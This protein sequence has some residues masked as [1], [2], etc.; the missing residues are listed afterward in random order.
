VWKYVYVHSTG[1]TTNYIPL[2]HWVAHGRNIKKN[3]VVFLFDKNNVM[4]NYTVHASQSEV[5]REGSD[6][7]EK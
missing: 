3:E 5:N 6:V 1:K 4:Q 7:G 2:V